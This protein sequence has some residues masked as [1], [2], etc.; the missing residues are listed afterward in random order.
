MDVS[1]HVNQDFPDTLR[2]ATAAGLSNHSIPIPDIGKVFL[3]RT[4]TRSAGT[5]HA[6]ETAFGRAVGSGQDILSPAALRV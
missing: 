5:G 4:G 3:A 1:F 6:P 2:P